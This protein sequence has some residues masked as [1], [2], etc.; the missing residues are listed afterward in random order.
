M[1]NYNDGN[2]H[3]WNGG[4]CP[5]HP[6]SLLEV[7]YLDNGLSCID[8]AFSG[9]CDFSAG[10]ELPIIAFRVIKEYREPREWWIDPEGRAFAGEEL[11]PKPYIHVREVLE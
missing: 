3:G 1:V 10:A 7:I 2:W 5:V 6:K 8:D 11:C 9:A 4:E